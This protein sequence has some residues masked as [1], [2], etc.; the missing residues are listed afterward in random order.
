MSGSQ[1]DTPILANWGRRFIAW[2]IDYLIVNSL[3]AYFNLESLETKLIPQFLLPKLP[4]SDIS[5]WSPLSV[6]I[7]FLYWTLSEWY[8]GRSIGQ[9]LLNLR[10]VEAGGRNASLRSAAVQSIGKSLLLPLDC[11][12]GWIYSPCRPLRQRLFNRLSRTIVIYIGK[13]MHTEAK[14]GYLREA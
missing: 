12:I 14:N 11:L 4:G 9:L 3:L 2:F 8:V 6:L 10:L 1:A 13:P 5:I 7:F